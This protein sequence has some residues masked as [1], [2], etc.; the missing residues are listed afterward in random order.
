MLLYCILCK[1]SDLEFTKTQKRLLKLSFPTF[2]TFWTFSSSEW[3]VKNYP[4][5]VLGIPKSSE[6]R[7]IGVVRRIVET[8]GGRLNIPTVVLFKKQKLFCRVYAA[9]CKH[10][11]KFER[12]RKLCTPK[13]QGQGFTQPLEC[14]PNLSECLHQAI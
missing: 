13:T 9:W 4:C 2:R 5:I 10:E 11:E 3:G 7:C 12:T 8:D 1:L 6:C 14:S